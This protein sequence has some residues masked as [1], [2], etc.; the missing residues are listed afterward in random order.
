MDPLMQLL[1]ETAIRAFGSPPPLPLSLQGN[2]LREATKRRADFLKL[3]EQ[4]LTDEARRVQRQVP[5]RDLNQ[6]CPQ[7]AAGL[8]ANNDLDQR[9]RWFLDDVP[10]FDHRINISL[11]LYAGY[12]DTAK[13][14]A[15]GVTGRKNTPITRYQEIQTVE[16]RATPDPIY[17]AGVETAPQYKWRVL[18]EGIY[19][20][21]IP[22]GS[23]VLRDWDD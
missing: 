12:L 2:P 7:L 18:A 13:V 21:G 15:W 3:V 10:D 4:L 20:E 14:I 6:Q 1:L 22:A 16:Q 8:R 9:T 5:S 19:S 17:R 11:R 23:I